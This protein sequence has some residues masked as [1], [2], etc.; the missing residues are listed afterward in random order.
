[1]EYRLVGGSDL[2][3][4]VLSLGTTTFGGGDAFKSWGQ[5]DA[6]Q[7]TRLVDIALDA[8]ITLFDSADSYSNGL[9][10]TILGQAIAGRRDKLLI[11][12]KAFF[13][14]GPGPD[15]VGLSRSHL[16]AACEA[17]LRRTAAFRRWR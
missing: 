15:G 3:V 12:T 16:V 8:G 11:S 13:R 9:A 17:S 2:K 6:A 4:S 14:T 10:E 7:A 5:T 1:M